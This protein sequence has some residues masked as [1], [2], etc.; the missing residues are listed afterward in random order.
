MDRWFSTSL[1]VAKMTW[2]GIPNF[3]NAEEEWVRHGVK[4]HKVH[5]SNDVLVDF[6]LVEA[7]VR[8][9]KS[10]VSKGVCLLGGVD[11]LE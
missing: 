8:G 9:I 11:W 2:F 6:G 1:F 4:D 5:D 7:P 10:P 3:C